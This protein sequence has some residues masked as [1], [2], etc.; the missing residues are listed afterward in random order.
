MSVDLLYQSHLFPG[1]QHWTRLV[2]P[3]RLP[4]AGQDC[5]ILALANFLR[6]MRSLRSLL[7]EVTLTRQEDLH[8]SKARLA[9]WQ[10]VISE[11]E[12]MSLRELTFSIDCEV[13]VWRRDQGQPGPLEILNVTELAHERHR[14]VDL[15]WHRFQVQSEGSQDPRAFGRAIPDHTPDMCSAM[16]ER[17]GFLRAVR[18]ADL[19]RTEPGP[20]MA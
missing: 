3:L 1:I 17:R 18:V 8:A 16:Q 20:R 14:L 7:L 5:E 4:W 15:F 19:V 11:L 10:V 13:L 6:R 9:D 2:L 12:R